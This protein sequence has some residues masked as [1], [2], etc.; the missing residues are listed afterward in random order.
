MVHKLTLEEKEFLR[1]LAEHPGMKALLKE[2]EN[3][4]E[5]LNAD[6]LKCHLSTSDDEKELVRRK[7]R[8]E[9]S[10]RLVRS[11]RA[12]IESLKPKQ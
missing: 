6:V 1:E 11:I 10:A 9:G 4:G 5:E 3:M 12:R 7:C 8:A 2:I